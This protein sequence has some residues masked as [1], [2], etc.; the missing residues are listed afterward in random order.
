MRNPLAVDLLGAGML[1]W[2][3]IA[4]ICAFGIVMLGTAGYLFVKE[5]L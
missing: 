3:V 1:G 5:I 2:T 4:G